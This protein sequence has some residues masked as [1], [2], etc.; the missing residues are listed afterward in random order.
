[1]LDL[2]QR[3]EVSYKVNKMIKKA[4]EALGLS[5][6][7][8][9]ITYKLKRAGK[10]AQTAGNIINFNSALTSILTANIQDE[11]AHIINI[12][13]NHEHDVTSETHI[14]ILIVLR[15]NV[16]SVI[17]VKADKPAPKAV[18]KTAKATKPKASNKVVSG[19]KAIA[20]TA[21]RDAK[22]ANADITRQEMITVIVEAL[23]FTTDKAGRI[24][25]AGLY[26]QAKKAL[27][28]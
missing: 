5:L 11:V 21:F 18:P 19:N 12:A 20:M 2:S 10:I 13:L 8:P 9:T 6:L 25:A 26:Q 17:N 24:K 23:Q 4:N 16:H 1:M 7:Q 28:A 15:C 22:K 14:N 27:E 3:M